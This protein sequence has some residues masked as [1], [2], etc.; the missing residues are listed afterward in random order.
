MT[1]ETVPKLNLIPLGKKKAVSLKKMW[2]I[3]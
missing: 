2:L 3:S 1:T